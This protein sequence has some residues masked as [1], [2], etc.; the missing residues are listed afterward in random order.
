MAR[1]DW[2]LRIELAEA[3]GFLDRLGVGLGSEADE[4]ADE[5]E[6]HRLAVSHD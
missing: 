5:L 2:R 6:S 3:Q 4:L 1:D